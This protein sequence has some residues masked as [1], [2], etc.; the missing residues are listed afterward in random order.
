MYSVL[1]R[2]LMLDAWGVAYAYVGAHSDWCGRAG[3]S[4]EL[5]TSPYARQ[6]QTFSAASAAGM[7]NSNQPLVPVHGGDT[8][9]WISFWT[10]AS[11]GV[12]G[13]VLPAGGS[14]KRFSVDVSSNVVTC[15]GHGYADTQQVVFW[16]DTV[17]AGL[18][19][20]TIYF[21]RDSTT[22]TFKVAATSGGTAI[23]I[24]VIASPFCNVSKITP[25]T[26][27]GDG[28]YKVADLDLFLD[29]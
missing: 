15:L 6:A 16:G 5:T 1:G 26:F 13:G 11:G 23:D 17:P 29:A 28:E 7:D 9:K 24:T 3:A 22:D 20:G 8:V 27:G 2:N 12:N 18:T 19:E 4:N 14:A 10:L 25:E 21:V